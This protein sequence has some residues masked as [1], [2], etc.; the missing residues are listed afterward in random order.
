MTTKYQKRK[1]RASHVSKGV[2]GR[3]PSADARQERDGKESIT[4]ATSA[5]IKR[6][7]AH[8]GG[9]FWR[10]KN[11]EPWTLINRRTRPQRGYEMAT[12]E[13]KKEGVRLSAESRSRIANLKRF[14]RRGDVAE[15]ILICG[16]V[17]EALFEKR[18]RCPNMHVGQGVRILNEIKIWQRRKRAFNSGL[19][20][21]DSKEALS[22]LYWP[23][24]SVLTAK[25]MRDCD[26]GR[27]V[28]GEPKEREP[29][30]ITADEFLERKRLSLNLRPSRP[31]G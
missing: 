31:F 16:R 19:L 14:L 17:I 7:D 30:P 4:R 23:K 27:G 24:R 29:E 20:E 13:R 25:E 21:P 3:V 2:A 1:S 15:E 9:L 5:E 6:A 11:P 22:P 26:L 28:G 10:A 8:P 18:S 12:P